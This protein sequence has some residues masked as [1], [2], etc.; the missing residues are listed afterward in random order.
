[1]TSAADN[2]PLEQSA[3]LDLAE[4]YRGLLEVAVRDFASDPMYAT[5][6]ARAA[7]SLMAKK[8][9]M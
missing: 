6:I 4:D 2:V 5:A 9:D 3:I 8:T 7:M 1:M